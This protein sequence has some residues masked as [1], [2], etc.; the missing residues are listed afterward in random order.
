MKSPKM[1]K[2]MNNDVTINPDEIRALPNNSITD[3]ETIRQIAL[4]GIALNSDELNCKIKHEF[5]Y[6]GLY[7]H[8]M[9][10]FE[11]PPDFD[12]E[13]SDNITNNGREILRKLKE[14]YKL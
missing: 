4:Y 3:P 9:K 14:K 1:K 8:I 11:F 5:T 6:L 12:K 2:T 10:P 13:L 7:P